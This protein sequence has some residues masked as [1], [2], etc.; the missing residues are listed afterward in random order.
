[1]RQAIRAGLLGD[2]MSIHAG[3]HWDHTWVTGTPFEQIYDVI[4]YDFSI[5]WFDMVS[6]ILGERRPTS[7]VA[8]R[9]HATGQTLKQP[10]L[11]Q[12]IMSFPGGQASLIFDAHVEVGPQDRTYIA[13]TLGTASSI[14]PHSGKQTLTLTTQRGSATPDLEGSWFP[15]GF[16][17]SMGELLCAIEEGREPTNSARENLHSLA[18]C[19]AAIASAGE[20]VPKTPGQVRRLPAGS[21]PGTDDNI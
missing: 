5:H 10:M 21:A 14:G 18:L 9:S 15:D 6:H 13:G 16:H 17:G 11:A 19:F 12:A 20:G 8:T 4:L 1:M 3:V 7:V 2:V